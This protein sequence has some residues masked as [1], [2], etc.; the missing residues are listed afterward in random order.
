VIILGDLNADCAYYSEKVHSLQIFSRQARV[1][2]EDHEDTTV[3]DSH[4]AYDRIISLGPISES[5]SSPSIYYYEKEL[6]I[7]TSQAQEISDHYPISVSLD[8]TPDSERCG[9]DPYRTLEN[10]CYATK[11][12]RKTRM[13][14]Y[15]CSL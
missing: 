3:S 2:I 4:C 11:D 1:W 5:I 7:N 13:P 12:Q 8:T 15:C 10:Y 14:D 9:T 6:A